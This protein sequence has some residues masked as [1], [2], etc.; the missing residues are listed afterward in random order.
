MMRVGHY[1]DRGAV[2]MVGMFSK[3]SNSLK[4]K[5][6]EGGKQIGTID[7][8]TGRLGS[9]CEVQRVQCGPI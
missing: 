7:P 6:R 8:A 3:N 5:E 4:G 2:G 1:G 9:P